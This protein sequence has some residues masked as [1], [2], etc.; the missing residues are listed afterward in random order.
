MSTPE[1]SKNRR[2]SRCPQCGQAQIKAGESQ[3]PS[4]GAQVIHSTGRFGRPGEAG[5]VVRGASFV[6]GRV[7]RRAPGGRVRVSTSVGVQRRTVD[8]F[9]VPDEGAAPQTRRAH[10]GMIRAALAE[11]QQGAALPETPSGPPS[12][13]KRAIDEALGLESGAAKP[14]WH[15]TAL[16]AHRDGDAAEDEAVSAPTTW[17]QAHWK[18][19]AAAVGG[20]VAGALGTLALC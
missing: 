15:D 19:I 7:R 14:L 6:G 2:P 11:A 13:R 3:C 4:C 16:S 1:P 5:P 20:A 18:V 12:G 10:P 9:A 8:P 17:L